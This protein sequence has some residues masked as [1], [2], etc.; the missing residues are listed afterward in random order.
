MRE[1]LQ[2]VNTRRARGS[3]AVELA[4]PQGQGDHEFVPINPSKSSIALAISVSSP[5][6]NGYTTFTAAAAAP[7]T[8]TTT[9]T[10]TITKPSTKAIDSYDNIISGDHYGLQAVHYQNTKMSPAQQSQAGG[11]DLQSPSGGRSFGTEVSVLQK[12]KSDFFVSVLFGFFDESSS[13]HC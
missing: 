3:L 12:K 8:T 6:E 9:T 10:T 13:A 11:L 2:G 5:N 4:M 7:S 1:S